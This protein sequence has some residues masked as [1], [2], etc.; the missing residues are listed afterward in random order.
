[1]LEDDG[2]YSDLFPTSMH[3]RLKSMRLKAAHNGFSRMLWA[4]NVC[5]GSADVFNLAWQV[6]MDE[7][8]QLSVE[9]V[10]PNRASLLVFSRRGYI[11]RMPTD[12]FSVQVHLPVGHKSCH[13]F[14]LHCCIIDQ[15][16]S[17]T[18]CNALP[19]LSCPS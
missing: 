16:Q 6:R 15:L 4:Y 11:K 13:K 2:I 3:F 8:G 14:C 10:I 18:I 19:R 17:L 1:M 7:S 5:A 12:L 9:D